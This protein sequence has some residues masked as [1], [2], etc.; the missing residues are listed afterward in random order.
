M[1]Q[2]QQ[3]VCLSFGGDYSPNWQPF[4][5]LFINAT[6]L[7]LPGANRPGLETIALTPCMQRA[8]SWLL[9]SFLLLALG[10]AS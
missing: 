2:V 3:H 6:R 7:V 1:F 5:T 9:T 10:Q 8:M 4:V